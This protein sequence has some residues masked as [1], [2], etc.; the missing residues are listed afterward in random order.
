MGGPT[1]T[2]VVANC[3]SSAQAGVTLIELM[4]AVAIVGILSAIAYPSY[5]RYVA[6]TNRNAAA[7]CLSQYAQLMERHYTT[8]L[9]YEMENPPSLACASEN[10]MD[11]RYRF[12]FGEAVTETTYLLHAVP[13]GT[14]ARLDAQCG[15]LTLDQRGQQGVLGTAGV[16]ACW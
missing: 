9:T 7:A 3:R 11:Q 2:H 4:I 12:E 16:A 13:I 6:R 10:D 14:Q 5:Q 1:M 15:T 8:K